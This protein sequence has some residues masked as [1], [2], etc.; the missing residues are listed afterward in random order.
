MTALFSSAAT[1]DMRL[2]QLGLARMPCLARRLVLGKLTVTLP[3]GRMLRLDGRHAGPEGVLQ[4]RRLR[5]LRRFATEG[6]VGFGEAYLDGDWD[7]PDLAQLLTFFAVNREAHADRCGRGEGMARSRPLREALG[8]GSGREDLASHYDLGNDFFAAWLDPSLTYSAAVFDHPDQALEEAQ[9]NKYRR[10]ARLLDLRPGQ[11]LLEI[12][13]GWGGFAR[14]AASE[15]GTEVT[16]ITLSR[17]QAEHAAACVQAEDLQDR[18]SVKLIDYRDLEGRFDRIASIE[19]FEAVGERH[20]P[21]YFAKLRQLLSEDGRAGLQ[22][23]T[24]ADRWF[25]RYRSRVDFIQRHVFPGGMLPS[26]SALRAVI[27]DA[28]LTLGSERWFG[29]DYART[30]ALWQSRF[31]AAWPGL[32]TRG[33]ETRLKRLWEYY[34]A[35][36]EAGF[37]AGALDVGQIAL[38]RS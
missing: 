26:L 14:L 29:L 2:L 21:L 20:W 35:Y 32:A 6:V 9:R 36:C 13:C 37:R 19:M 31:Q 10:L 27:A 16:A 12:G 25:E 23:I 17:A 24:I 7:S 33:Y 4:I 3:G 11:R 28:G 5:T 34:L 8:H 18:V 22:L 38:T 1:L 15:Y 30:L